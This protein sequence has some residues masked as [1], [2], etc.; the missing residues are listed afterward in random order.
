M[1]R[2]TDGRTDGILPHSIGAAALLHIHVDYRILKQG[3]GTADH[4][5]PRATGLEILMGTLSK[6]L[7]T[8]KNVS[9]VKS[10]PKV[11]TQNRGQRYPFKIMYESN[12][13]QVKIYFG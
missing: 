10:N 8:S 7:K 4:M 5:M 2:W 12:L 3:K 9:L 1:D 11:V 6:M 13:P